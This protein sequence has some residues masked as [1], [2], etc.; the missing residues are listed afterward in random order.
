M[1]NKFLL[2]F[3]FFLSLKIFSLDDISFTDI[4]KQ[5]DFY[6]DSTQKRLDSLLLTNYT[7]K[8]LNYM[9]D[10]LKGKDWYFKTIALRILK[11]YEDKEKLFSLSNE[12]NI[13]RLYFFKIF[14]DRVEYLESFSNDDFKT[15]ELSSYIDYLEKKK[16]IVRL[17]SFLGKNVNDYIIIKVL[18]GITS[19]YEDSISNHNVIKNYDVFKNLIQKKNIRINK[20]LSKLLS[21]YFQDSLSLFFDEKSLNDVSNLSLYIETLTLLKKKVDLKLLENFYS[22]FRTKD[23]F[24]MDYVLE[25]YFKVLKKEDLEMID[26]DI[27]NKHIRDI[28]KNSNGENNG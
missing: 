6:E 13:E 10:K 23:Y 28:I 26:R 11:K 7:D 20:S 24:Y 22:K 18:D 14:E 4:I 16:D 17:F 3:I 15:Y 27:I 12:N 21:K 9:I 19:L 25:N 8:T 5:L 1:K 2:F